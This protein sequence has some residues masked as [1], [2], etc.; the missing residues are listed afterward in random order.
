MALQGGHAGFMPPRRDP[1]TQ[2]Q[3]PHV[4]DM[5]F[6]NE[7]GCPANGREMVG[8]YCSECS[9]PLELKSDHATGPKCSNE[10]CLNAHPLQTLTGKFCSECGSPLMV[11]TQR[12]EPYLDASLGEVL[13]SAQKG[14]AAAQ[15]ELGARYRDGRGVDKDVFKSLKW[16]KLAAEQHY[17]RAQRNLGGLFDVDGLKGDPAAVLEWY[18][19][20]AD[21]GDP[22]A[23]FNLGSRYQNGEGVSTDPA[24][25][26]RWY[27]RSAGQGHAEAQFCLG[28]MYQNGDGVRKSER[29]AV[30]WFRQAAEKGDADAQSTLGM[31][32]LTGE[33]LDPDDDLERQHHQLQLR[34]LRH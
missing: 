4:N 3:Q 12:I 30:A 28:T 5:R 19:K 25:A 2:G 20:A 15:A 18:Q 14:E 32:Y 34:R 17:P 1:N 31:L 21:Q 27:A 29:T 10:A 26:A 6:C 24:E 23:Q 9:T 7:D 8:K 33:G 16:L 22:E 11:P 13:Q